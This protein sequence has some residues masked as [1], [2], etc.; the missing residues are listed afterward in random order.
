MSGS[1]GRGALAWFARNPV[2]A[3]LLALFLLLGGVLVGRGVQQE[4]FPDF[5][6]DVVAIRVPY[7]GAS[8]SEVEAGVCVAIEEAVRGID[9][10]DRVSAV[11]SEGV[12]S[13][14][15]FLDL[16][17]D[18]QLA[19]ADVKNAVDRLT[20]LPEE[21]ER[22][23]VSLV[24]NRFE[25]ISLV[26]HGPPDPMTLRDVAERV[27][28]ELLADDGITTVDLVGAPA[29][30]VHVEVPRAE[31]RSYGLTLDGVAARVAATALEVP[32]GSIKTAAGE[33]LLRTT[34]RRHGAE[35][36]ADVPVVTAPAGTEVQ[37]EDIA[38][39]RDGFAD[40]AEGASYMGEPAIMLRVY[41]SGDQTPIDVADRV[42]AHVERLS[43]TL[44]EGVGI[45]T[46][47]DWSEIY[48]QR[49]DLL[50]DNAIMGLCLVMLILGALLELRLAFWVT[51]GIPTSFL[52][53]LLLMPVFDVS[54]NMIS[55]FAFI[56]V[57]GMVVDDA[58]V[59]GENVY[60]LR[61][62][63]V[64]RVEAAIAGVKGVAIP[65]C[66]AVATT[67]AAFAPMLFVPGISGKLFRNIPTIVIGVLGISLLEALFV[68]PA[69]LGA[70]RD[71][72]KT[73]IYA[74]I[75][76][77]QQRVGAAL[78]W[79][80]RNIYG[81]TLAFTLRN[82]YAT[83]A[84][85]IAVL[86][87][88]V[89]WIA[90]GHTGFRFM[91]NIAGD[92]AIAS[93]SLP[94]G[95]AIEDT[96]RVQQHLQRAAEEIL[97]E[98]GEDGI[99]RG[100]FAQVGTPLPSE[101]GNPAGSLGGSHLANVQV[102]FVDAG[103]R[104]LQTA[105]FLQAWRER[106]GRIAGVE[107][108]AFT[109]SIG[110][111][112]GAPISFELV[113]EDLEVLQRAAAELAERMRDYDGVWDIDDGFTAGKPQFD[114]TLT[115]VASSLGLTVADVAR[116]VR[117]AFY[118]AEAL[119]QQEGRNEV[120][121]VVRLPEAERRSLH[122]V[123]SMSIRT[124]LGGELPL[125]EVVVLHPGRAYPFIQRTDGRR[126]VA[127]TADVRE[128]AGNPSALFAAIE[129]NELP[130]LLAKYPGLTYQYGGGQREQKR[131]MGSLLV[132]GQLALLA[133]FAMLAIPFR[134]YVQPLIVMVSIPFG[135][136]GALLGHILMGFEFSMISV[137]GLVALTGVVV[138]DAIVLIDAANEMRR[139]SGLGPDG[140]P[141]LRPRDAIFAAGVRRFRPILLTS[142]TT[143]FG[144]TP[145]IFETSVQAR[146]LVPMAVSL[147]FGVAFGTSITLILI[148]SVYLVVDDL[149][150]LLG[151]RPATPPSPPPGADVEPERTMTP[152]A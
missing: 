107:Q 84:T 122:D 55:L 78:Q 111:G 29:R 66:F 97:A 113:H 44:P 85:A 102:F 136:I 32:G 144:L 56:V 73:G 143:F 80:I 48:R 129:T 86:L 30:E 121:V 18:R 65:V 67:M 150:R 133:R 105:D 13:V 77:H 151:R 40:T 68:L 117:G 35:D 112:P 140:E 96:R 149:S 4:V 9:G 148:P 38:T 81:R 6:L 76:R 127:V 41:R 128:G 120:K 16:G 125:R 116:Q 134:S 50:V 33:V 61:E 93:V 12:G 147:G 3:N 26:V 2:A 94:Y 57:L 43:Q 142:S 92:L 138:N 89:G 25:V 51:M 103:E 108:L 130:G 139:E 145:M 146:F 49:I 45:A 14:F 11:A 69:H 135:L 124:P 63:G 114:M 27:R 19:L 8:P 7:P 20:S 152:G 58:I 110:P 87:S 28:E 64:D 39:I 21:A 10:V 91:P 59:V 24:N 115:P 90:G 52:G 123:E 15:V 100:V 104:T 141:K 75:H 23:I 106:V 36:F 119:R 118:G 62:R 74:F 37:L 88:A 95:S 98:N 5:K 82:R 60:E 72:A 101:P 126:M 137:M 71:P 131:S 79:F 31:L 22:P 47:T 34:E 17:V 99:V 83:I 46:W 132:G 109:A 54:V 53:A 70:L 1:S 42:K